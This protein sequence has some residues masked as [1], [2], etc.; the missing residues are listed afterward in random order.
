MQRCNYFKSCTV[1]IRQGNEN[2][3]YWD[4]QD[5]L[6]INSSGLPNLGFK[7]YIDENLTIF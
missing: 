5:N 7:F 6:S 3:I 1:D 2:P 4:N